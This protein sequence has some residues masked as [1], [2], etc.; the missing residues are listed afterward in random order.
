MGIRKGFVYRK[1]FPLNSLII[2]SHNLPFWT[3]SVYSNWS[4]APLELRQRRETFR[5]HLHWESSIGLQHYP[6]TVPGGLVYTRLKGASPTSAPYQLHTSPI[7]RIRSDP[8]P[9]LPSSSQNP[10]PEPS[11]FPTFGTVLSQTWH[12]LPRL[13]NA[14]SSVGHCALHRQLN[15]IS[16]I[17][18][19]HGV[20]LEA[21][22]PRRIL[23]IMVLPHSADSVRILQS[24]A[25]A[26]CG[27]KWVDI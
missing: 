26:P 1:L 21:K 25:F 14:V 15:F 18:C 5:F 16:A 13:A 27:L 19:G 10:P 2:S 8:T 23:S 3:P 4:I 24:H 22:F 9:Q 7:S 20:V 12:S 17:L 11:S 6:L